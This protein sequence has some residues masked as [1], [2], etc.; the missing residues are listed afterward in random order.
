MF[1]STLIFVKKIVISQADPWVQMAP[2]YDGEQ[3][4]AMRPPV[5]GVLSRNLMDRSKLESSL[6]VAG[7]Q[8]ALIGGSG[9]ASGDLSAILADLEHPAAQETVERA[10][11]TGG[12]RNPWASATPCWLAAAERCWN[13]PLRRTVGGVGLPARPGHRPAVRRLPGRGGVLGASLTATQLG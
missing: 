13:A 1:W 5:V 8:P 2:V 10:T 7:M 3:K 9:E 12:W 6:R 4:H 11:E